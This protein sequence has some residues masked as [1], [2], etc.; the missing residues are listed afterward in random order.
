MMLS[1]RQIPWLGL[2]VIS[3]AAKP[4]RVGGIDVEMVHATPIEELK[5]RQGMKRDADQRI[6]CL[7]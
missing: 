7:R 1:F 4:F 6:L 3:K 5:L 2:P